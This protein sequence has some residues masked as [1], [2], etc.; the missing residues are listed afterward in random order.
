MIVP[1]TMTIPLSE[2]RYID[3]VLQ[4]VGRSSLHPQA[5]NSQKPQLKHFLSQSLSSP[6]LLVQIVFEDAF[7]IQVRSSLCCPSCLCCCSSS[8]I[9]RSRFP[10]SS[11]WYAIRRRQRLAELEPCKQCC[12]DHRCSC[13]NNWMQRSYDSSVTCPGHN[14]DDAGLAS[15]DHHCELFHS[16]FTRHSIHHNDNDASVG[17]MDD[18][19]VKLNSYLPSDSFHHNHDDAGLGR[20]DNH[21]IELDSNLT[22]DPIH[23][24]NNHASMG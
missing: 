22:R 11:S 6:S 1:A 17:R 12:D 21:S 20:M 15:L 19:S 9:R 14:H 24:Y 16:H 18:Y 5:S 10:G 4:Q 13:L 2:S 3:H 23:H 7:P 8:G